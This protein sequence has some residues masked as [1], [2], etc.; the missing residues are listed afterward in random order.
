MLVL[1]PVD[2]VLMELFGILIT[3]KGPLIIVTSS[4]N[5]DRSASGAEAILFAQRGFTIFHYDKRGTGN[6]DL[7]FK[8]PIRCPIFVQYPQKSH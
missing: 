7:E 4:G 3:V 6:S 5:S 8:K 1:C 2:Q